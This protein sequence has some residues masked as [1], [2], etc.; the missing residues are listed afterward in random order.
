MPHEPIA[1]LGAI[2]KDRWKKD[3]ILRLKDIY[4]LEDLIQLKY[5]DK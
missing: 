5:S 2:D 3:M 4:C 1:R